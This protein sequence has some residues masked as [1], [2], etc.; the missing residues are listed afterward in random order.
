VDQT[1]NVVAAVNRTTE[2][3]EVVFDGVVWVIPPG[4]VEQ[5]GKIVGAGRD[6][7][8][9]MHLI[10]AVVADFGK[11]QNPQ[12]GTLDPD[13]PNDFEPKIGVPAWGDAV[14]YLPPTDSDELLDRSLLDEEAQKAVRIH[15][16]AG[17]RS[18][19]KRRAVVNTKLRNP[20]GI[21]A[22]Y[23]D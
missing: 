23:D 7:Q 20:A 3:L 11:R 22:S 19:K 18:R 9:Y 5:D 12:P 16:T 13:T 17:R 2:P 15:T 1:L 14:T 8:P 6:G 21:R 4:Y 10:P